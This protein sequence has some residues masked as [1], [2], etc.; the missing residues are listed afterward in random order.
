MDSDFRHQIRSDPRQGF[1]AGQ[2]WW[3]GLPMQEMQE[4]RVQY[5]GWEDPLEEGMA[6]HSSVLARRIPWTEGPGGLQSM[7]LQRVRHQWAPTQPFPNVK[8]HY[9][10]F[11]LFW[12]LNLPTHSEGLFKIAVMAIIFLTFETWTHTKNHSEE[13]SSGAKKGPLPGSFQHFSNLNPLVSAQTGCL[14]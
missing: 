9:W 8:L 2:R 5:L 10:I 11:N 1:P 13:N 14:A 6:T 12:T 3:T 7:G 4:M